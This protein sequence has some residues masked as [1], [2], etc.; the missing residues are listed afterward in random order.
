MSWVD[1]RQRRGSRFPRV[2]IVAG[3]IALAAL[4]SG[5]QVRPL[6]MAGGTI[7]TSSANG[8]AVNLSSISIKPVGD[9]PAQIVRNQL[10]FLLNGGLQPQTQTRYSVTLR[11][12]SETAS[13][14]YV[15]V[16]EEDEPTAGTVTIRAVYDLIDNGT[17]EVIRSG[18]RQAFAS[19]D[20]S[21]QQFSAWRA[22]RDAQERAG[23]EVAELLRLSLAQDLSQPLDGGRRSS[24]TAPIADGAL[25]R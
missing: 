21:R 6:Y 14:A 4:A 16:T 2:A 24:V 11:A 12:T 15:Q 9:R 22:E 25:A 13:A 3:V 7:I 18:S 8:E 10:I 23:R 5:C 20:V 17:G 1:G 19:Y